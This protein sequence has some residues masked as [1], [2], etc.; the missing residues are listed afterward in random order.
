MPNSAASK[1]KK[2]VAV[3]DADGFLF[4]VA[5]SGESVAK[6]QGEDGEDMYFA[7]LTDE[8]AYHKVVDMLDDIVKE[9]GADSALVCLSDRRCFRY[10]I[11]PSYKG[12][13]KE[14][15]RPPL[16]AVLKEMISER[17]PFPVINV[18]GLEADDVCGI[19]SGVL[20]AQ[21][22]DPIICSPDKDLNTIPGK[23]YACRP[24]SVVVT[25]TEEMADRFHL[26]QTL[27]GD[28]T[29]GYTGCPKVGPVRAKKVLDECD[30]G[31]YTPA[32]RWEAVVFQFTQRGF[33]PE[34]ALV[35][36]RVARILR[37]SDWDADLKV[38]ILWVPPSE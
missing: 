23:L 33:T 38:P 35:Q 32:K 13:R 31:G 11:L 8:E 16:L 37:A 36:A 4:S 6:G 1:P 5:C 10:D 26:F 22:K 7:T 2:V 20:R 14:T 30:E 15:R 12:N 17:K 29:D 3:I 25:V 27:A 19:T 9:V 28:S 34:D 21:G 18:K 24:G